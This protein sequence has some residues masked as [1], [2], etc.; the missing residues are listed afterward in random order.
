MITANKIKSVADEISSYWT[1][2][3]SPYLKFTVSILFAIVHSIM[4][5]S[6]IGLLLPIVTIY[7]SEQPFNQH[8]LIKQQP[9]QSLFSWFDYF[10][11]E[12]NLTSLIL[13][14]LG[15]LFSTY[16]LKLSKEILTNSMSTAV[17]TTI[18]YNVVNAIFSSELSFFKQS[19]FG[20]LS[21]AM[22]LELHRVALILK[23]SAVL[24][25]NII[26]IFFFVIF[27]ATISL[28]LSVAYFVL[29]YL[30]VDIVICEMSIFV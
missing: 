12:P 18:R 21:N 11:V 8:P 20:D 24:I 16:A 2:I 15:V 17:L 22:I 25:N 9:Y 28:E 4:S 10:N 29:V 6:G 23:L 27:M 26:L 13:F 7:L 19:R 5:V 1:F 30:F 14:T 3:G